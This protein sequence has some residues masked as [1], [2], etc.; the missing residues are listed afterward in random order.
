MSGISIIV[1][2]LL[3]GIWGAIG[4]AWYWYIINFILLFI[5]SSI[6]NT[7]YIQ[8][9]TRCYSVVVLKGKKGIGENVGLIILT[10]FYWVVGYLICMIVFQKYTQIMVFL[11]IC[12]IISTIVA[13]VDNQF[14]VAIERTKRFMETAEEIKDKGGK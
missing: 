10:L 14:Q 9:I 3:F 4:K 1:I 11:L 5:A 13:F 8:C 6:F 12:L 7:T 2:D